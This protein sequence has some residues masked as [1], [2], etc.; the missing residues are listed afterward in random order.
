M[1]KLK[2]IINKILIPKNTPYCYKLRKGKR[3]KGSWLDGYKVKPCP[4]W[5]QLKEKDEYGN[6]I[7]YCKLLKQKSE[8]QDPFN[9]IWDMVKECGVNDYEE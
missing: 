4:Y 3:N 6:N 5:K 2:K 7:C 9:L 1:N 8:Y